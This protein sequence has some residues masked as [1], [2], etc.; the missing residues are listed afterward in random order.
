MNWDV[1]LHWMTHLGEG[2]WD[3]FKD[4][5]SRLAAQEQDNLQV[6]LRSHISDMAYAEFFVD[7]S[8]RWRVFP[9]VLAELSPRLGAAVLCGGRT[10]QLTRTLV[11]AAETAGCHVAS[12]QT[13]DAPTTIRVTGSLANLDHSANAVGVRFVRGYSELLS[14]RVKPVY[15]LLERAIEQSAPTNWSVRSFD[16]DSMS[17]VDGYRPN[18]A[19]ECSPRRG[20]PR[21]YVHTRHGRL[22]AMPKR[23]AVYA[24]AMLRGVTLLRYDFEN[25]RLMAPARV[26]PPEPSCRAACLCA[27]RRGRMDGGLIVFDDVP[28][29][30]AGVLCVAAGQPHPGLARGR[31]L[32]ETGNQH[33]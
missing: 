1:L 33:G 5:V 16:F 32:I 7:G 30:V 19:C 21:W 28:P 24:A 29:A 22:R 18:S 2:S 25:E 27:G 13:S 23:E 12:E 14:R 10:P 4:A 20:L 15:E 26:P 3:G 31:L 6:D 11:S 8:R 9:P 17:L